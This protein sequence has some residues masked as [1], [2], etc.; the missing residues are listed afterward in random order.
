MALLERD[1]MEKININ[2]FWIAFALLAIFSTNSKN[3]LDLIDALVVYLTR[4]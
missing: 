4:Q 2:H 3:G 1:K